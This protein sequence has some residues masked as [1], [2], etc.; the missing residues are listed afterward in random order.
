MPVRMLGKQIA[1][2]K[3]KKAE[4]SAN[5]LAMPDD[6]FTTGVVRYVG[7]GVVDVKA[8]DKVHFGKNRQDVKIGGRRAQVFEPIDQSL[9]LDEAVL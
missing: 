1:V 6:A 9:T 4:A 2:E 8:G 5:W 7:P 3:A